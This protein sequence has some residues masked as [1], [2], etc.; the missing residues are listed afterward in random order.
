MGFSQ[1]PD[2]NVAN[3][4]LTHVIVGVGT[5]ARRLVLHSANEPP[6]ISI[7]VAPPPLTKRVVLVQDNI[8]KRDARHKSRVTAPTPNFTEN[9][10]KL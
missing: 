9:C 6:E 4:V 2:A 5:L 1:S 7:S 3:L 8:P 10:R